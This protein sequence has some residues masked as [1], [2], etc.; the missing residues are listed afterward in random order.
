MADKRQYGR[1]SEDSLLQ[2]IASYKNGDYGLNKCSRVYGVPKATIKRHADNKNSF[3]NERKAL[4]RQPTF[5]KEMEN[6]LCEHILKFE[7]AFYGLTITDIR[8]LAYDIAEKYNLPHTFSKDKQIAGKKWFYTFM[9]R[10]KKLSLRKPEN[11]SLARAKAFNRENVNHFFDLLEKIVDENNFT[12]NSIYN[13]DESGLSTVQKRPQKIVGLKGKKQIG[14][15]ASGERGVNTTL[16]VCCSASGVYVPPMII[17]KRKKW[18]DDLKVGAPSGSLVTISET[19][20][21]NSE[22]FLQWL[23]HFC[24]YILCSKE[25]KILLLL[26]GHTTHSKNLEAVDYARENGII[27][28]QLPGH[29]THRLQPLDV[30]IFGPLQNYF[31]HA[32]ETYLRQYKG[33][34]I[35]QTQISSL[36]KEAYGRAATVGNAESAFRSSGVWP[37]N[38]H[39]FKDSDFAPADALTDP[40]SI[41]ED[42]TEPS[43]ATSVTSPSVTALL[44]NSATNSYQSSSSSLLQTAT[45][46]REDMFKKTL[47]DISPLPAPNLLPNKRRKRRGVTGAQKAAIITSSPYKLQLKASKNKPEKKAKVIKKN[48]FSASNKEL[49]KEPS[50]YCIICEIDR[51]EEMI[52]CMTCREWVHTKCGGINSGKKKYFCPTC[53]NNK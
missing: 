53:S 49:E 8:K 40:V 43:D 24:S 29:T 22:L 25:K 33:E 45:P 39:I 7:E 14:S 26:D 42:L 34:K 20:Y 48:I 38:R 47:L 9:K 28:L 52:Q 23:K 50:W 16:V 32:Q 36:I 41:C 2:A 12:G 31:I 30:S 6:I 11:T 51:E 17:F 4:G 21:I 13:V 37:V 19:G 18:S 15:I 5:T 3:I 46:D 35:N 44:T 10:N 27:L 1:W